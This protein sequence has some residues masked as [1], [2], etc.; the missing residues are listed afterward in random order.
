LKAQNVLNLVK[1]NVIRHF[2]HQ[3]FRSKLHQVTDIIIMTCHQERFSQTNSNK[4]KI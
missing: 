3:R 2:N 4:N 1:I